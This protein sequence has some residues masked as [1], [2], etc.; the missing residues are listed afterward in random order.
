MTNFGGGWTMSS[1]GI[2]RAL[3]A[4]IAFCTAAPVFAQSTPQIPVR[5]SIDANG[6]DLFL[7]TMSANGPAT[8][9]GGSAPQGLSYYHINR[10][11]GWSDSVSFFISPTGS[12]VTV[13]AGGYADSFSV[14]GTTY[15]STEGNGSTLTLS[16]TTYAYTNA[17]GTVAHFSPLGGVTVVTD[18]TTSS[19]QLLSYTY[20][21]VYYCT[22]SKGSLCTAH[23]TKYRL[24][25][26]TSNY[27]YRL[28]YSYQIDNDSID[29]DGPPNPALMVE[30]IT[31]TAASVINLAASGSPSVSQG[32]GDLTS[33]GSTYYQVTDAM[34]RQTKYRLNGSNG[35][36]GITRAGSTVEDVTVA[37]NVTTGRVSSVTTAA[38]TWTYGSPSDV[39]GVR[40]LTVTD[41]LGHITTFTFD[42]TLQRMTSLTDALSHK[43]QWAYDSNG[44]LT[45]TTAPEGNYVQ[46]TLDGRGNA[47]QTTSVAKSGSGLANIVTSAAYPTSCTNP[48]TCNKP[49]STTDAN[50]N[51]TSYTYDP[52][53]GNVLTVTAPAATTG[54]I[55]AVTTYTYTN[56][57]AYYTNGTS[58][59]A[60]GHPVSLLTSV[61]QCQTTTTCAAT[62]DEVKTVITYGPQTAGTGNN[63]LPITVIKEAG[64]GSVSSTITNAYDAVGNLSSVDGPIAG[65]DDTVTYRY[66]ADREKVGVIAPDPD[67]SGSR[68]RAAERI[69]YDARGR[70]TLDEKG[71]VN[72][73]DNPSW[74]AFVSKQAAVTTYDTANRK[75]TDTL[76]SGGTTYGVTQYSYDHQ[77]LDCMAV[78]MNSAV[79][80]TLPSDA[81]TLQTTGSAGP[82]RIT[83]I[84]TYDVVDRPLAVTNAYNTTDASVEAT[85]SY[86]PNGTKA[87]L[88]DGNGNLTSY[89]YD[90]FDRLVKTAYPVPSGSGS[91]ATDYEQYGYDPNGNVTSR[92]LRDT[93]SIGYTYDHRNRLTF[94]DLPGTDPD[95]TLGYDLLNRGTSIA[96]SAQTLTFNYDSLSRVTSEGGPLGTISFQYDAAGRRT[97]MTWPDAFY[98]TYDYDNASNLMHIRESGATSGVGVLATYAYDDLGRRTSLTRGNST[99]T[100]YG[101]DAVSR[102]SAFGQDLAGTSADLSLGFGYNPAGQ[103]ASNTRSNDAFAT[104][105]ADKALTYTING[106]NQATASSTDTIGYDNMGNVHTVNTDTYTYNHE[107]LLLTGPNSA[108]YSYDPLTRLYQEASA[109]SLAKLQYDGSSMVAEYDATNT[110]Q[111]RYVFGPGGDAPLVEY[112]KSGS[113]FVRAWLHADE[114]GSIIVR[115]DDTGTKTAINTYDEYGVPGSGNVGRFQYTGQAWLP[116]LGVYYYKARLY[117][118]RLGRFLQTDPIGYGNGPN[119]YNYAGGDPINGSDPSGLTAYTCTA[120]KCTD[121]NGNSVDLNTPLQNGDTV[122]SGSNTWFSDGAGGGYIGSLS[123]SGSAVAG[124]GAGDSGAGGADGA[125][126]DGSANLIGLDPNADCGSGGCN[127][128]TKYDPSDTLTPITITANPWLIMSNSLASEVGDIFYLQAGLGLASLFPELAFAGRATEGL[129]ASADLVS[130]MNSIDICAGTDCADIAESIQRA[131]SGS[132]DIL[133][134]TPAPG[135][136][137]SLSEYGIVQDGNLYHD[138][139]TDG[140]FAYDPRFSSSAVPLPEYLNGVNS[141]NPGATIVPR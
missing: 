76:Q 97:R 16:G 135:S 49:T 136:E 2:L 1:H 39:S 107:N 86:N 29:P 119:W 103:I 72:G 139:Y 6:V 15:T 96:T 71:T 104:T 111:K 53:S 48:A 25:W 64:N 82:D 24:A 80:G 3:L 40:T 12:S 65:T 60:S 14:S 84:T 55:Q 87:T 116:E 23:S 127:A 117:S 94:E 21:S 46:Y 92:R 4:A 134:I 129:S 11:S 102:L 62:S 137:L 34:G 123:G 38:G 28:A 89:S 43:T 88:A 36:A 121:E 13:F 141:L 63:L 133:H 33:G 20:Q 128:T 47:T 26:I 73:T 31:Q 100:S 45:K 85:V 41:P 66:D 7:G 112:D 93:T 50:G 83:R 27:G 18:V 74:A 42:I 69:T 124:G 105:Y 130:H 58:I 70:V 113:A 138:V 75:L 125:G 30:W 110:L 79:W 8:S 9:M 118:S 68:Q 98:V 109:T 51:T 61:S 108:S 54:G 114:R 101:Y 52:T 32:F 37:Y 99:V 44:R 22:A 120:G 106:L 126:S 91:S 131:A 78:R 19:G 57:Q 132:G 81:C 67:G 115:T 95:V 10:G 35:I 77:R 17:S 90:G 59:V 5:Q 56:Y 140:S 122:T